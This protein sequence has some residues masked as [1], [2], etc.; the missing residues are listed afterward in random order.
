ME[1]IKVQFNE[2]EYQI[3]HNYCLRYYTVYDATRK[4][5]IQLFLE[6]FENDI[7]T[8]GE[9]DLG[10]A[11]SFFSKKCE[12]L[13]AVNDSQGKNHSSPDLTEFQACR[14]IQ[15]LI[16]DLEKIYHIIQKTGIT[17]NYLLILASF[18]KIIDDEKNTGISAINEKDRKKF[19]S[20][21]PGIADIIRKRIG[22]DAGW[23]AA[24]FELMRIVRKFNAVSPDQKIDRNSISLI[25][26]AVVF[27]FNTDIGYEEI[28]SKLDSLFEDRE[29]AEFE[30]RLNNTLLL[31]D[32]DAGSEISDS[33]IFE[34]LKSI[35]IRNIGSG[36]HDIVAD[37]H[38]IKTTDHDLHFV[39]LPSVTDRISKAIIPF[40][41]TFHRQSHKNGEN[42]TGFDIDVNGT[43]K[44]LVVMPKKGE[45]SHYAESGIP[46]YSIMFMAIVIFILFTITMAAT[47]GIWNPI[48]PVNNITTGI[49]VND[50]NTQVLQ[51]IAALQKDVSALSVVQKSP[52]QP[53]NSVSPGTVPSLTPN[54]AVSSADIN[55][56][57]FR[58][59]FGPDNSRITKFP[60]DRIGLAIMGDT[61]DNDVSKVSEFIDM[62]NN[63]S[64]TTKISS[65]VKSGDQANIVLYFSPEASIKNIESLSG[66]EIS[67]D[68]KTGT[69]HYLHET[70]KTQYTTTEIIY[71]NAD[72]KGDERAHWTLR[73]LLYELG[74]PGE[75]SDTPDSI[76]YSESDNTTQ[77]SDID[78]KAIELMYG[79]KITPGLTSD[80]VK[81]MLLL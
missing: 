80:R 59:A 37:P 24:L 60:L 61:S 65:F 51:K 26:P 64:Y 44:S 4:R 19:E 5:S 34:A 67:K 18:S 32:N 33:V 38:L 8:V 69:I 53:A 52:P 55:K 1:K 43:E 27:N 57:F 46:R 17:P 81:T 11:Y 15:I 29:F 7:I 23:E 31:P 79:Q 73:G 16:A 74:F 30:S 78:W 70:V 71:I 63:H 2:Q 22:A 28:Q 12:D 10:E 72:Y 13:S 76:F 40:K 36:Y 66:M 49:T 62:F 14:D 39:S 50:S 41:R 21:I 35:S 47:S 6:L 9:N 42:S 48:K 58:I 45:K 3:Y 20:F 56:H 77:L 25:G 54:T 68:T 75:T